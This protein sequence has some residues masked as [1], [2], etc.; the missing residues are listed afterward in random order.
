MP[1]LAIEAENGPS[2]AT[3]PKAAGPAA[4]GNGKR[5]VREDAGQLSFEDLLWS[6]PETP[7]V[8]DPVPMPVAAHDDR[9]AI[10]NYRITDRD[11]LGK[12]NQKAKFR[13]NIRAIELLRK[14]ETEGRTATHEEQAVLVKYTGWGGMPQAF[15]YVNS[16]W[17]K[18]YEELEKLLTEEE[19]DSARASTLNAHYTSPDVIRFM[20]AVLG[21]MGFKGGRVLEPSLGIG[22]FLCLMPEEM[23]SNSRLSGIELESFSGRIAKQLCLDADIRVMGFENARFPMNFFDLVLSN[24]PFGDYKLHDPLYRKHKFSIH[25]YFFAKSLDLVRPGGIVAF[26]TSRYLMDRTDSHVRKYIYERADL[27][28]AV[29]LPCTAFREIAN[30]EVTSDI[31]FLQKREEGGIPGEGDWLEAVPYEIGDAEDAH[32]NEYFVKNPHMML[33]KLAWECGMYGRYDLSLK[34]DERELPE[35]LAGALHLFPSDIFNTDVELPLSSAERAIPSPDSVKEGAFVVHEGRLYRSIGGSLVLQESPATTAKRIEKMVRL[36]DT[37]RQLLHD[38][39][40]TE[41]DA[42]IDFVRIQLNSAYDRFV[43]EFGYINSR[44]NKSAFSEDPDYP[45]LLSLELYDEESKKAEKAEVFSRRV[46]HPV[47]KVESVET[48]KESFLVTLNELGRVDFDRMSA[49]TGKSEPEIRD[50]LEGLIFRNPEGGWEPADQ[51]LSGNVRKKLDTAELASA[52]DP[53]FQKNVEALKAVQ[54]KEIDFTEIR[55]NLGASWIPA[56]DVEVFINELIDVKDACEVAYSPVIGTW[57]VEIDSY[58]RWEVNDSVN[59]TTKWGTARCNAVTLIRDALNNRMSTVRDYE[60]EKPVIN[61]KETEAAREKQLLVREHFKEWLWKDPE[62]RERLARVYNATFNCLRARTFDGSH[63][64]LPGMSTHLTLMKHQKDAT[65]R[66]IQT[67]TTLIDHIV[68]AGKSFVMIAAAMEMRRLGLVSKAMITVPN[69]L[70]EQWGAMFLR[71]YPMANVLIAGHNDFTP[72]KRKAFLGKIALNHWDAVIIAHSSFEK[73]PLSAAVIA[74]HMEGRIRE[75]EEAILSVRD[76]NSGSRIVK[77]IEKA[78]KRL[79]EKLQERLNEAAKDDGLTF[80]ELGVD[81]LFVDEADLFKNLFIVTK[82]SRIAGLPNADSKRAFDLSMKSQWLLRRRKPVVFATGTPV[83]N[84]IAEM[85]TMQRYQQPEMLVEHNISHFDSWAA[86]FGEVVTSLEI[87]PDGSGYRM[88]SRFARFVN[89]PELLQMYWQVADVQTDSTIQLEKPQLAGGKPI[90]IV[91]PASDGQKKYIKSLVKRAEALRK[92]RIDPRVDNML[93]ITTDGRKAA[94]DMRLVDSTAEDFDMSKVNACVQKI[95]E[96]WVD[97]E[98]IKGTQLVFCDLSTP[99]GDGFS[100]Y[101]DIREKLVGKGVPREE[102]AFIHEADTDQK[103]KTLFV[104]VNFGRVR[105]LIGSTEKMGAGTNVQRLLGAEHHLDVP[106]RPRDVE[107]RE[108]RIL[109]QGNTNKTV[110]IYRYVTEGSFDAYMWQAVEAKG[111]FIAQLRSNQVSSRVVEDVEGVVLSYAEV[112]ALASG[113]P[114]V[115]EKFKVDLEVQRLETLRSQ[116]SSERYRLQYEVSAL[117]ARI[118]NYRQTIEKR[119]HDLAA[120]RMPDPFRMEIDGTIY[121]E[122]KHAGDRIISLAN[123][124]KGTDSYEKIGSYAGFDLYIRTHVHGYSQPLVIA[125]GLAE[126]KGNVSDSDIGTVSSLDIAL[127]G[128]ETT[129]AKYASELAEMEKRLAGLTGE[130]EKPFPH[131]ERLREL[132]KKQYEI[133]KKLDIDNRESAEEQAGPSAALENA[134]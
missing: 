111:R 79:A 58:K 95:Y 78:K 97:M 104:R 124:N 109:R 53:D 32:I 103:K 84:T 28:G 87:A 68:G 57:T 70:L 51:Y 17:E 60:D 41:D 4:K 30:T 34:P 85:Y 81:M 117:P 89:V 42:G 69:H 94:L 122:R 27:L 38:E 19:Y 8:V 50:E 65:W 61:E 5:R 16:S 132:L 45:L 11:Q 6:V 13:D 25:E 59:N 98:E 26:I 29:R 127:R 37:A 44:S 3:S 1:G 128:M 46:I 22:Y 77:E 43:K 2:Q 49:L 114:L 101:E 96:E 12:G 18:E 21:R 40:T 76:E 91:A 47:R 66:I 31:V 7:C 134:A 120:R 23:L 131:E 20:Y 36:R 123:L 48:V 67:G 90:V 99:R 10:G 71:L 14:L 82:M 105:V 93:K 52:T 125:R 112:K 62:R 33:G 130:L 83:S 55:A 121:T 9:P 74:S 88:R 75:L 64:N 108:G 24:V 100:V 133:N 110:R 119:K 129:I 116:H 56:K 86:T 39:M 106:W 80:E 102:I 126:H 73:I 63:L 35:A 15:D 107:Q 118:E 92:D 113:N 72:A 115:M 54:P